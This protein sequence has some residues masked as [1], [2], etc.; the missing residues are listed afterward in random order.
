MKLLS[1]YKKIKYEAGCDEAG[2]G[3]LAGPVVAA[4]VI[5]N[6]KKPIKGLND[7]K[8]LTENQRDRLRI[9]IEGKV[10]A[11]SV[12]FIDHLTI[13]RI[14]I[15]Q[16][17]LLAMAKALETINHDINHVIIDGNKTI[18]FIN[19]NQT[20]II[21]GDAQYESIAAASILAKTYR[22]EFMKKAHEEFPMYQWI[23]NM[24]Y[25]SAEHR[26]AIKK[27]GYSPFHR[28]SFKLKELQPKL[29]NPL[30]E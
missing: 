14:N 18:P 5:L 12:S 25:A 2:R 17:S 4:A 29:F 13:D 16:A 3:C 6:P 23:T 28:K 15:L 20:A 10:L 8:K 27:Y 26:E 7:S 21:K 19:L 22:D 9:E 24:G 30:F 11:Y 1:H